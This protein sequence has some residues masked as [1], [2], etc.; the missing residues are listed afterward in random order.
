M[1]SATNW[2]DSE[3]QLDLQIRSHN[4]KT[5]TRTEPKSDELANLPNTTPRGPSTPALLPSSGQ[6]RIKATSFPTILGSLSMPSRRSRR[7]APEAPN[8][9]NANSSCRQGSSFTRC[10]REGISDRT[11]PT[12]AA[13]HVIGGGGGG[14]G[15]ASSSRDYSCFQHLMRP[16]SR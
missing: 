14:R 11:A 3:R 5:R 10:Y 13:P 9:I 16:E 8:A 6:I 15:Q 12:G 7:K 2:L 4:P 1:L